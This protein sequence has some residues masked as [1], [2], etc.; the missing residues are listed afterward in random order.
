[1]GSAF[2][3]DEDIQRRAVDVLCADFA[4]RDARR[5]LREFHELAS[6]GAIERASGQP[7][8]EPDRALLARGRTMREDDGGYAAHLAADRAL[9]ERFAAALAALE[10]D[11]FRDVRATTAWEANQR[12]TMGFYVPAHP[13]LLEHA[14]A[15]ARSTL[16]LPDAVRAQARAVVADNGRRREERHTLG[17]YL[18]EVG[19]RAAALGQGGAWHARD[20]TLLGFA[21]AMRKKGSR[22]APHLADDEGLRSRL[23]GASA[24]LESE[25]FCMADATVAREAREAGTIVFY[26]PSH[27]EFVNH[28]KR[29][30]VPR[31][32]SI[33]HMASLLLP[34][35]KNSYHASCIAVPPEED[36]LLS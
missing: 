29:L 18:A 5:A 36:L 32:V 13:R 31:M 20:R 23:D 19:P 4:H 9:G 30:T 7:W 8:G 21:R 14:K 15:L 28:A 17:V 35:R 10:A 3:V 6:G 11:A 2:P 25:A 16:P 33:R 1:M 24:A 12:A 22:F 27:P 34:D 26:A